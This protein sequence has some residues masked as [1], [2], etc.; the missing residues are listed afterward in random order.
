[1]AVVLV[2]ISSIGYWYWGNSAHTLV[3]KDFEEHSPYMHL[4]IGR[5]FGIHKA[6]DAI[7]VLNVATTL[8]LLVL[9]LQ[10]LGH[11][12]YSVE[13]RTGHPHGNLPACFVRR[14][15]PAWLH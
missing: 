13:E 8:P 14:S 4:T 11:S 1:M 3:T 9:S 12:I 2:T 5:G 6:V 15:P 10:D 7:V